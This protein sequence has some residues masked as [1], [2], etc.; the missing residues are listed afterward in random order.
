MAK[1]EIETYYPYA[2]ELVW[3]ALTDPAA[4]RAWLMEN[5]FQP[6]LGHKFQ[7]K[8]QP[9]PGWR[10][11]VDCE[12]LTLDRPW[13][14]SYSW[15]GDLNK[16]PQTVTWT[17]SKQGDGTKLFLEHTGFAGVGGFLLSKMVMGPGWKKMLKTLLPDVLHKM[18]NGVSVSA[19]QK[20]ECH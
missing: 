8:A 15:Q 16:P 4:L 19:G 1:I 3:D 13:K 5:D 20:A 9:Q 17:L 18:K 10:G 12:V 14:L 7:F 2:P 11:I 6:K